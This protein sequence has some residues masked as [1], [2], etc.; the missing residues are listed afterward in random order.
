MAA[1]I[2]KTFPGALLKQLDRGR[3]RHIS[4]VNS[5]RGHF[6]GCGDVSADAVD[7][8][9]EAADTNRTMGSR[10]LS[11]NINRHKVSL[12][13]SDSGSNQIILLGKRI[14]K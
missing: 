1:Q 12:G 11:H 5:G 6:S 4:D 3:N 10:N 7:A 9:A 2:S 13:R 14:M 8:E